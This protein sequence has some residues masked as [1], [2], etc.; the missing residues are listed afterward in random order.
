MGTVTEYVDQIPLDVYR[1]MWFQLDRAPAHSRVLARNT[2]ASTFEEQW[3]RR[4]GPRRWPARSPDLTPLEFFLCVKNEVYASGV[5][6]EDELR[7]RIECAFDK[8]KN[9]AAHG[10][11][12]SKVRHRLL[13]RCNL[14]IQKQGKQL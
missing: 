13:R 2:L 9:L 8:I 7:Q 1:K 14:C 6:T 12:L 5:H 10:D 11:V 3:I 4:Y